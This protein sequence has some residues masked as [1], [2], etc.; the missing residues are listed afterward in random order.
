MFC[1]I[2]PKIKFSFTPRWPL[3]NSSHILLKIKGKK[4]LGHLQSKMTPFQLIHKSI[5]KLTHFIIKCRKIKYLTDCA[6]LRSLPV[7]YV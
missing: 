7:I 2:N 5:L 1:I 3:N 6:L 4:T